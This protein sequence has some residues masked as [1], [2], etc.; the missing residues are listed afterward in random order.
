MKKYFHL[1]I[2]S[3]VLSALASCSAT[4]YVPDGSYLLDEIKIRTDNKAVRP[5]ALRM[6]VRQNPNAKWF[7]LIKTQLYVYNLSGRDSTRWGNKFLRRIGDAPVIYNEEEAKR[8]EEE[9]RKAVQNMG[10]MAASVQRSVKTK[11][12]K[13]KLYF[14]VTTDKPYD[15][16]FPS[17]RYS[18]QTHRSHH[19]SGFRSQPA[20]RRHVF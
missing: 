8:S 1:L 13:L 10:Y 14:D 3:A 18:R 4:K 15:G 9:I 20:E 16:P 7:S 5:S 11:K 12:K 17:V 6:Y 19:P 2:V